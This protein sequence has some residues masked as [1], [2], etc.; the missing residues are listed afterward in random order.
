MLLER[1]EGS[2]KLLVPVRA[3]KSLF[4]NP[5]MELCRDIDIAA[6]AALA[7]RMVYLDALAGTGVRGIRVANEVG[8]PVVLNDR[9]KEAY[10]VIKRNM[11][12]NGIEAELFN[13]DANVL[14]YR[15]RYDIIDID[16]FGSPVHF[17]DSVARSANRLILVTATDTAPLC[18]AHTSGLRRYAARALN[19]EYHKEM[20]TRILLGRVTRD[21]CRYDKAIQ[22]LLSYSKSHFVRIIARVDRGAKRADECMQ[23]LGFIIHCFSCGNRFAVH[24]LLGINERCDICGGKLKVAGPLYLAPIKDDKFC[25]KVCNE[26]RTR[27]MGRKREAMKLVE[28]C[29]NELDIP[30]YYEYHNICKILKISPPPLQYLI[31]ALRASGYEASR[32]HFSDTGFKTEAGIEEIKSMLNRHNKYLNQPS[33]D[34]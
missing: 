21:L 5:M 17:L 7:T 11:E 29:M 25:A 4:Y 20:A 22:P 14:M 2:T 32:T 33:R 31:D 15:H 1:V 26:L 23:R 6:I 9:S 13:E 27:E 24:E 19:T 8:L 34:R 10:E 3:T 12:L 30:F 28:T 16:P 18:G